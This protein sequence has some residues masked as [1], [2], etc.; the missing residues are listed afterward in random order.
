MAHP[1]TINYIHMYYYNCGGLISWLQ[2][3]KYIK[4]MIVVLLKNVQFLKRS[5]EITIQ[6][7]HEELSIQTAES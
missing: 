4:A 6:I 7:G 2:Y 3:I 5:Y 1:I